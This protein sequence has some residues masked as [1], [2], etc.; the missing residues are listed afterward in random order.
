MKNTFI[1]VLFI[2]SAC[3]CVYSQCPSAN[4]VTPAYLCQ[5]AYFQPSA[6][7]LNA[8]SFSWDLCDGSTQNTPAISVNISTL[9]M[10]DPYD[11]K[12]IEEN[13]SHYIFVVSYGANRIFRFDHG[14]DLTS[15]PTIVDLGDLGITRPLGIE[16]RKESSGTFALVTTESGKLFRLS[17]GTSVS[18][19]P[20]IIEITGLTGLADHRQMKIIQENGSVFALIAGGDTKKVSILNFGNSLANQPTQTSVLVPTASNVTSLDVVAECGSKYALVSTY[21]DGLYLMSFGASFLNSPSVTKPISGGLRLGLSI[22]KSKG[23][24]SA[25]VSTQSQGIDRIDF[26]NTI[27]NASPSS[28]SL[29]TFGGINFAIGH[30]VV[31]NGSQYF[32]ISMNYEGRYRVL[33]FPKDCPLVQGYSN[34][35]SPGL[36]QYNAPGT[37][38]ITLAAQNANEEV[39]S[40]TNTIVVSSQDAPVLSMTESHRCLDNAISFTPAVLGT[41]EITNASWTFGDMTPPSSDIVAVHQYSS[42]GTYTVELAAELTDGCTNILQKQVKIYK[43]PVADFAMPTGLLCTNNALIFTNTTLD[44]FDG[45]LTYQWIVDNT[46]VDTDRHLEYSFNAP[47]PV[48]I[49]LIASIPGCSDETVQLTPTL[50]PGPLVDFSVVGNCEDKVLQF[51]SNITG[52]VNSYNWDFGDGAMSINQNQEHMFTDNGTY[53]VKLTVSSP[54]GCNNSKTKPITIYSQPSPNFSISA[55]PLSCSG[56]S[57]PFT[58]LTPDPLDSD[59][60]S[61]QWNFGDPGSENISTSKDP[62]HVFLAG[63]NY[64]V[65]L[66]TTTDAGCSAS[67]QKSITISQSPVVDITNSPACVGVP[68]TFN[69]AGNGIATYYWEMG[70]AYYDVPN[71]IHTFNAAGSYPVRLTIM[72]NND[73]ITVYDRT[74][75]VPVPLS[76]D[77]SVTQNCAGFNSLFSDITTGA[78]PVVQRLWDFAGLGTATGASSSFNFATAAN[79]NIKLTVVSQ[80]GCS[81]TKTKS[82]TIVDAPIAGFTFTPESGAVPLDV[83]FTN[84]STGASAYTWK[85]QDGT[86]YTSNLSSPAYRFNEVGNFDVDLTASNGQGCSSS[87]RKTVNVATAQPD[88]DLRLITVSENTDGTLKII[89]TIYNKGNTILRNLPVII[90]ISGKVA[91]TETLT[92]PIA[93]SSLYNLV[94]SYGLQPNASV[95]FLCA[96]AI[97]ENDLN[98]E[99]NKICKEFQSGVFVLSAY[100]NPVI[101]QI[102]VEWFAPKDQ[103]IQIS[104]LDSFGKRVLSDDVTSSEGLNTAILD[105]AR[106]SSGIYIL[107]IR[108]GTILNTQRIFVSNQN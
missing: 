30:I 94:L 14:Q 84:T 65:S 44:N 23:N 66:T 101:D 8:T 91:L 61:W 57:T 103:K 86:G 2:L 56:S 74:I 42:A 79:R 48:Q 24:F 80:A 92:G 104:L 99:G 17:F 76:P 70:T 62:G 58:D 82:V 69:S 63:G 9:G 27:T 87:L 54:S 38:S 20:S 60:Q 22:V 13:G 55:P 18:S 59:I 4:I 93:P 102:N 100:P 96:Q 49:K 98:P 75:T 11:L 108:T 77:F 78:D 33:R 73:C 45:M 47:D 29:G 52:A 7:V 53:S 12:H 50:V 31:K 32:D 25:F 46:I 64:N 19:A 34:M 28:V 72:G 90:G 68:S 95:N 10:P 88:V 3:S 43:A 1:L 71:P 26:G 107:Q 39:F 36:I 97:L 40:V 83:Q 105:V 85:F 106:L 37:Y 81:Y 16:F 41:S 21:G 15:V 67:I 35:L 51:N 5:N 89:I 6:T